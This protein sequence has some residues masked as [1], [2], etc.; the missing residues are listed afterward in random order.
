MELN[1]FRDLMALYYWGD[2]KY[3]DPGSGVQNDIQGNHPASL[4]GGITF[5]VNG[6]G[7]L[8]AASH[9]GND[10]YG[11][12]GDPLA[13]NGGQTVVAIVKPDSIAS[14]AGQVPV[15]GT[16]GSSSAGYLLRQ[17]NDKWQFRVVDGGGT[18]QTVEAPA[19]ERWTILVGY[20][21]TTDLR[22]Y[23]DAD[24]WDE[25]GLTTNTLSTNNA[26]IG[27][28]PGRNQWFAGDIAL[29]GRWARA[30][31]FGEIEF[32][33]RLRGRHYGVI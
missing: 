15:F 25:T 14:N 3:R 20:Y 33:S 6:P 17:N 28:D 4:N 32:F 30:L 26:T 18:T 5:D 21:D 19:E 9:D 29:V 2:P 27:R 16:I 31:D 22:L 24:A 7:E 23:V 10:D 11:D 12:V 13:V 8:P 1:L